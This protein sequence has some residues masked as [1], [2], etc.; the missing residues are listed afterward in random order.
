MGHAHLDACLSLVWELSAGEGIWAPN[1]RFSTYILPRST[2]RI[3]AAASRPWTQWHWAVNVPTCHLGLCPSLWTPD[4]M[5]TNPRQRCRLFPIIFRHCR[6]GWCSTGRISHVSHSSLYLL[7]RFQRRQSAACIRPPTP[8]SDLVRRE[9]KAQF[10]CTK[11]RWY[12]TPF[13]SGIFSR[14]SSCFLQWYPVISVHLLNWPGIYSC[15]YHSS[16][17]CHPPELTW[18]S[19][20]GC[21]IATA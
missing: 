16:T 17:M 3:Q 1:R 21:A 6:Q 15:A 14:R 4:G 2:Q 7:V 13:K 11:G 18:L 10:M 8:H 20:L 9:V 12:K 5:G 19:R